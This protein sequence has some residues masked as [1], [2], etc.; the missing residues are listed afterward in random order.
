MK[1]YLVGGA[2]RRHL[3]GLDDTSDAD[4][5][6]EAPTYMD[7]FRGVR[8]EYNG[9][10]WQ[11]RKQFVCVRARA[12]FKDGDFGGVPFGTRINHGPVVRT[13]ADFTLC[14]AET[15][16][17]DRR[18]PDTVTPC[19]ILEDLSRRDF[20]VNAVAVREDGTWLDPHQ[21]REDAA[22]H[23]LRCVGNTRQ[24][25][26]EDP[27]RLLRAVRFAVTDRLRLVAPLKDA[28]NTHD[29]V[30]LL[31]TL[32]H[33]RVRE[34]L[35]KAMHHNWRETMLLLMVDAPY[36]GYTLSTKFPTLWFKPTTESR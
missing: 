13:N 25:M 11:E 9:I 31:A 16:Y 15:Q 33:E 32:P 18:H 27:L 7:M 12:D 26:L 21:G 34:E 28:L 6:V 4:F 17:S 35:T 3:L 5:A 1:L 10:I 36:L 30:D 22:N 20:T 19:S 29:I 8:D 24:R 14:R 23:T 2:V